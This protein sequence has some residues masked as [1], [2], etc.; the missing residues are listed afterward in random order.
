MKNKKTAHANNR[1]FSL[2]EITIALAVLGT[3]VAGAIAL[4]N[5]T[6]SAGTGI[7]SQLT[8]AHLAQEGVEVIH[9]I[10]HTN[11]IEFNPWSDL[12]ENAG[13]NPSTLP[14]PACPI[15]AIVNFDSTDYFVTGI[16]AD[17]RMMWDSGA[18][19]YVHNPA[20]QFFSR[21]IEIGYENDDNGT[22][23]DPSDDQPVMVIESIV[24]W[25]RG[26]L[27]AEDRLYDW[28]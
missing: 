20:G 21:H 23:G 26:S 8:A 6:I 25:P 27:S 22:P 15:Q 13:C 9:N 28:K 2:L 18:S 24:E 7:R 17:W 1:G 14:P 16:P 10:R 12:L 11:W 4:I 19:R 3:G 5:A